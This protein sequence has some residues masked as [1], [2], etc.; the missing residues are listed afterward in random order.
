MWTIKKII[1]ELKE[2]NK[3]LTKSTKNMTTPNYLKIIHKEITF[4]LE[5]A[6]R[7]FLFKKLSHFNSYADESSSLIYYETT[8]Q[9]KRQ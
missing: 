6:I 4:F 5:L 8:R 9:M 7:L 3:D 2:I 1:E